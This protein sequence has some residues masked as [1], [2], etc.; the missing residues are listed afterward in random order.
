VAARSDLE[1]LIQALIQAKRDYSK[2]AL[3]REARFRLGEPCSREQLEELA[4][5]LG[6]PLPP[7]YR[8]F[9]TLHNGWEGFDGI[10][11]L[12]SV[13]DHEKKWVKEWVSNLS[14]L[15]E[16]EPAADPFRAGALPV[17]LGDGERTFMVL[18]PRSSRPNGEMEFVSFDYTERE[19]GFRTFTSF[20]KYD[21]KL[22]REM[23]EDE[24]SGAADEE[25]GEE[26]KT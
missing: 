2:I 5:R 9:L 17:L 7:S 10:A 16:E 11:H 12:L 25:D 6:K 14:S 4:S 1:T 18:D 26:D 8:A 3:D 15:F 20:L 13:E 24:M 21:L 22:T 19:R 23:I